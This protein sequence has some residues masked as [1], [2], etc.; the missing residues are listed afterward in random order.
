MPEEMEDFINQ[1]E[2]NSTVHGFSQDGGRIA[3][4]QALEEKDKSILEVT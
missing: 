4:Y 1:F 3:T 2:S